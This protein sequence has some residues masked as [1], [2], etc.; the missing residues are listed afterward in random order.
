MGSLY[1]Y[2]YVNPKNNYFNTYDALIF[3]L[4][5]NFFLTQRKIIYLLLK[6]FILIFYFKNYYLRYDMLGIIWYFSPS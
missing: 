2:L 3:P 4:F 1:G 6:I 5:Y